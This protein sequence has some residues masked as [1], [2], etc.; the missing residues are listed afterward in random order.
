MKKLLILLLF[1]PLLFGCEM[2]DQPSEP[3]LTGGVWTFRDYYVTVISTISPV[4]VITDDVVCI[5]AFGEQN[6]VLGGVLMEQNYPLT[7][8]D[9]K[10]IKG[11]T[12]WEFDYSNYR[13][14]I[15]G[16]MDKEYEVQFPSYMRS[17]KTQKE[18]LNPYYGSVTNYTFFTDA[19]GANY[20]LKLT[21]TSPN[22]VSDI[23]LSNGMRDK[24]VTVQIT[25][26]FTRN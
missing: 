16:D 23:L 15:N 17:E 18:V 8:D 1:V 2:Y 9:R 26:I 20:P 22:I 5:N 13:L 10:F 14:F 6:Y 4:T 12:T 11:V 25:L 3:H 24:A 19:M 7:L 21:L